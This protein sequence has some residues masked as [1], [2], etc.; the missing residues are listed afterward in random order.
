MKRSA[1]GPV[2][3]QPALHS[4]T[5]LRANLTGVELFYAI[6]TEANLGGAILRESVLKEADFSGAKLAGADNPAAGIG[7]IKLCQANLYVQTGSTPA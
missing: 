3:G 1:M 7:R 6:L 4:P 5:W 2:F